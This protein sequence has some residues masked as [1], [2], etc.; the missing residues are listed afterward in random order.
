MNDRG[1]APSSRRRGVPAGAPGRGNRRGGLAF[2][3]GIPLV[4]AVAGIGFLL[5]GLMAVGSGPP[6]PD[7]PEPVPGARV[8]SST[9]HVLPMRRSQPQRIQV[10]SIHVDAS[11]TP[12]G[13]AP[14]GSV[15]IPP[16][17]QPQLTGWY[18][19]GSAPGQLGSAVILG[20]VDSY[21]SGRA[22][23]FDLGRL[24]RG[25]EID[26]VRQDGSVATFKVDAVSL[27]PRD[28]FPASTVYG[29]VPYPG[30]RLVTCAG[31]WDTHTSAYT[32]NVVVFASMVGQHTP[33]LGLLGG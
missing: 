4:L 21:A 29:D 22:V 20:H 24:R 28:R 7:Y 33:L 27:V 12:V 15:G 8:W 26:V 30:L 16:L 2:A 10:P 3:L 1:F 32:E 31:T 6:S 17:S 14:D 13:L 5:A 23:F 19:K 9:V 25:A 18:R 11:V